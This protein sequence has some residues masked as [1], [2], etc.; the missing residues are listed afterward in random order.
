MAILVRWCAFCACALLGLG[1]CGS[2]IWSGDFCNGLGCIRDPH[3]PVLGSFSLLVPGLLL[4]LLTWALWS[5]ALRRVGD[6]AGA[7][8]I[9]LYACFV[10]ALTVI[11]VLVGS[12]G[13]LLPSNEGSVVGLHMGLLGAHLVLFG[14]MLVTLVKVLDPSAFLGPMM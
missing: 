10:L 1:F 3:G 5:R 13:T 2:L 7:R 9:L 12:G 4:S 8:A 11:I 14:Y 6:R